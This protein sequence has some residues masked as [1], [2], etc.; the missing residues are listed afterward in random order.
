MPQVSSRLGLYDI[1]LSVDS[2]APRPIGFYPGGGK[3]EWPRA[4]RG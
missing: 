1:M 4:R 3:R 2:W